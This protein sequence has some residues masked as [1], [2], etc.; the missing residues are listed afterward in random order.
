MAKRSHGKPD[1]N[2]S[3]LDRAVIQAGGSLIPCS[4]YPRLGFDRL[5][6][7]GGGLWI[8][9]IKSSKKAKLT[10]QEKAR[11]KQCIKFNVPYLVVHSVEE[12]LTAIGVRVDI[13]N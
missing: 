5:Y 11:Q 12:L 3:A 10:D 4:Q 2:Q 1:S 7:Y 9:E 8:V 6:I 13:K